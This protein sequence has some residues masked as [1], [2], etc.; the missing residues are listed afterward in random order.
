MFQ[1]MN[2]ARVGVAMGATMIGYRG[3][4]YSLEYARER[5][6]GRHASDGPA[7]A[8]I[9]IVEHADVRRML[10]AQKSYVEGGLSLC[11]FGASLLDDINT[12]ESPSEIKETHTLLDL[13]TPVVKSWC[14]EFGPKANDL[15]IQVLG[16]S[17]YTREYP[18]EQYWRDNRLN[19]I[20][21]GTNGIQA[22]DLLGRKVWQHNSLGLQLLGKR[23]QSDIQRAQSKSTSR[24]S[25]WANELSQ[26]LLSVQ[27]ITMQLGGDLAA[28]KVDETLANAVCYMN[29]IGKIVVAWLWLRQAIAAE[30]GLT[31]LTGSTIPN[32]EDSN[33]YHGKIQATQYFFKW[34]LTSIHQDLA[35]LTERDD[36][37]Y[38]MQNEWF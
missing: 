28:N 13:L 17:G 22:L 10:L 34:E 37:C 35:L 31:A 36:T 19:P 16:G 12:L 29:I 33:F 25:V 4:L 7:S 20:H 2:E 26:A 21:E 15:A 24:C 8:P 6:Q 38:A 11:L 5:L 23:M 1:M 32:T 9:A 3:Y 14:S 27:K 18:V 30:D